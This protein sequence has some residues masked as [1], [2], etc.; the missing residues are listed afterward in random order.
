[1]ARGH[2]VGKL[3]RRAQGTPTWR[4]LDMIDRS[5]FGFGPI[6]L[7]KSFWTEVQEFCRLEARL[8]GKDVRDLI[9]SP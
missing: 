8:S 1:M 6:L 3:R 9:A 4:H 7:Q 2:N 5:D